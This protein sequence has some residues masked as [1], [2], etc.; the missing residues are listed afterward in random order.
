MFFVPRQIELC[1][2]IEREKNCKDAGLHLMKVI[3]ADTDRHIT[4]TSACQPYAKFVQLCQVWKQY[5]TF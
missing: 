4:A 5:Q 2:I 1:D 3:L